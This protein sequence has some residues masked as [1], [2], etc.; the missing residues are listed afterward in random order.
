[1]R[2]RHHI[3]VLEYMVLVVLVSVTAW[4]YVAAGR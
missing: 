3:P 2:V 1:M 4:V